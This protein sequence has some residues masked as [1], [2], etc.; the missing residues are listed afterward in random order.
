MMVVHGRAAD[1]RYLEKRKEK[2]TSASLLIDCLL[3]RSGTEKSK[4]P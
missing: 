1:H 3:K 4:I 2:Y